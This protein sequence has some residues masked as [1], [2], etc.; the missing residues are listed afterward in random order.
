LN[1]PKSNCSHAW[2]PPSLGSPGETSPQQP[3][4]RPTPDS[5]L[6]DPSWIDYE[7]LRTTPNVD[8]GPL[9]TSE[10]STAPFTEVF[11]GASAIFGKG[12]TFLDRFN[13]DEHASKRK[14]NVYYPFASEAEWELAFFLHRS[15]LSTQAIDSFFSLQI[16]C[17]F[18]CQLVALLIIF[19]K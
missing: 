3:D 14:T 16:V 2:F 7:P 19:Y 9:R 10:T 11:D 17:L 18:P 6:L 12:K 8:N 13:E 1:H 5:V 4:E 15:S